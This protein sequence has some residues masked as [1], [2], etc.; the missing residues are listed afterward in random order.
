MLF[1]FSNY[2][3]QKLVSHNSPLLK[4]NIKVHKDNPF[5]NQPISKRLAEKTSKIPPDL[6]R[7][8]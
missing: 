2:K 1:S 4:Y 7:V 8:Q 3:A 6:K 5:G